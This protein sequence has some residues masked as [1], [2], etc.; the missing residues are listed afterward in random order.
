MS[1]FFDRA[2]QLCA[3]LKGVAGLEQV[4]FVVD[5]QKDVGAELQKV[6]GKSKTL[7]LITWLGG[8]SDPEATPLRITSTYNL[9]FFSA[10]LLS[11]QGEDPQDELLQ[12]AANAIHHWDPNPELPNAYRTRF[13]V[14][15]VVPGRLPPELDNVIARMITADTINQLPKLPINLNP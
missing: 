10:P 3:Y 14:T 6:I 7:C 12:R 15:S 8:N 1:V 2:D 13:K 11:R 5:R 4:V 9:T